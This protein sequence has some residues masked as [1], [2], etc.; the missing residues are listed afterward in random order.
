MMTDEQIETFIK[1]I[2][3]PK[4]VTYLQDI[5]QLAIKRCAQHGHLWRDIGVGVYCMCCGNKK[6]YTDEQHN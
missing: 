3:D 5:R 4:K 1:K 2:V 6:E